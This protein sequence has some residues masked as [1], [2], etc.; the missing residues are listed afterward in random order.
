MGCLLL[1]W[2]PH[3]VLQVCKDL[4]Y[5]NNKWIYCNNKF[6]NALPGRLRHRTRSPHRWA[7][8]GSSAWLWATRTSLRKTLTGKRDL[9]KTSKD[10]DSCDPK[11]APST[12]KRSIPWPS[13]ILPSASYSPFSF[14]QDEWRK[15]TEVH[16]FCSVCCLTGRCIIS[17][18]LSSIEYPIQIEFSRT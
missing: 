10:H 12:S 16:P 2:T 6:P 14:S 8:P 4:I 1:S 7:R 13:A 17:Q 11:A 15:E 9:T 5:C 18:T 3:P